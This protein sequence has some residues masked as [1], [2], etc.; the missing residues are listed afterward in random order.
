VQTTQQ[1]GKLRVDNAVKKLRTMKHPGVLR[2]IDSIE[3]EDTVIVVTEP[4][5][6]LVE[7]L[8]EMREF[9]D[10]LAWG[11]SNI[12]DTLKF[13]GENCSLV[14]A[15][16][17]LRSIFVSP[18][19][20]WKLGGVELLSEATNAG[21]LAQNKQILSQVVPKHYLAPEAQKQNWTPSAQFDLYQL[22]VL[23]FELFNGPTT[24][25]PNAPKKVPKVR[26]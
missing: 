12:I 17:L 23:I 1:Q 19:G 20:E 25:V 7:A 13:I 15:Q 11:L 14:H 5:K 2:Y 21:F 16:V 24:S 9:E 6:P 18:A 8:D 10:W 3:L 26:N 22:G 4:V